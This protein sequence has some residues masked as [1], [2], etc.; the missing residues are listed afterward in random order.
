MDVLDS[1]GWRFEFASLDRDPSGLETNPE[2]VCINQMPRYRALRETAPGTQPMQHGAP[3][4]HRRRQDASTA[5]RNGLSFIIDEAVALAK[6]SRPH[7]GA[8]FAHIG[9]HLM[10]M[11]QPEQVITK[12]SADVISSA[13]ASS[14]QQQPSSPSLQQL[15]HAADSP[16]SRSRLEQHCMQTDFLEREGEPACLAASP[17]AAH[18]QG[19]RKRRRASAPFACASAGAEDGTS[20]GKWKLPGLPKWKPPRCNACCTPKNARTDQSDAALSLQSGLA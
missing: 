19:R 6:L 12:Q 3:V 8:P 1:K 9:Q 15:S 13:L 10:R 17:E 18:R 16:S 5:F 20:P 14:V 2:S 7:T 4:F 11:T